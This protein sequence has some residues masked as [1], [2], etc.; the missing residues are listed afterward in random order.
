VAPHER[1][2]RPFGA[3]PVVGRQVWRHDMEDRDLGR[4][5]APQRP[6][7]AERQLGMRT[8]PDG[9]EHAG[10]VADAPLLD[11]RDVARRVAHDL[12]DRGAEDRRA[13]RPAA[14]AEDDQVGVFLG[15]GLFA[16]GRPPADLVRTPPLRA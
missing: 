11:H 2:Q 10:H 12:V 9:H 16:L 13:G 1:R 5:R 3:R 8:A 4:E 15:G 14:P 7:E 6:G